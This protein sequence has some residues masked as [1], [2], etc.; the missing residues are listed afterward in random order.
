[1]TCFRVVSLTFSACML[2]IHCELCMY[3]VQ[4]KISV[5]LI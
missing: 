4:A 5:A 1:M 3:W 2:L